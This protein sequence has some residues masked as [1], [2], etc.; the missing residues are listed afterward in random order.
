M[1]GMSAPLVLLTGMV[2]FTGVLI[3]WG[4]ETHCR[5]PGRRANSSPSCSCW[6]AACSAC[7]S[8]STCSCCSSSMRSPS[9]RCTC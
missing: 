3:S 8:R 1:D 7:S 5:H 4:D 9:S 2:M 6:R